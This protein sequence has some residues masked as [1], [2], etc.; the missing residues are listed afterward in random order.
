[1]FIAA[2]LVCC[3][4]RHQDARCT[5]RQFNKLAGGGA[6]VRFA[7]VVP[8]AKTGPECPIHKKNKKGE[9]FSGTKYVT[10]IL[11]CTSLLRCLYSLKNS[12]P[13]CFRHLRTSPSQSIS[14]H[15]SPSQSTSVHLSPPQS[16]SVHLSPLQSISVHLSPPQSISV[17]LSPPQSPLLGKVTR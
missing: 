12:G 10:T 1:M 3:R 16:I 15:L 5:H 6:P 14:V 8:W 17:H 9:R 13:R 2:N 11:G 4:L 7:P